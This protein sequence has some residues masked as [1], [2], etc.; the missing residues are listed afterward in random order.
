MRG[1][2]TLRPQIRPATR[3]EPRDVIEL[4]ALRARVP[5][6]ATAV[7]LQL[8]Q[9]EL[10]RRVQARVPLPPQLDLARALADVAAGRPVLRFPDLPMN[11]S[12]FR[13]GLRETADLLRRFE[14]V[15]ASLQARVHHLM[16]E[17]HTME[18]LVERWFDA[19]LAGRP[20][21]DEEMGEVFVRAIKPFLARS[22]EVWAP[23][24]DLS[25][26]RRGVCPLCSAP[27]ELG[28]LQGD[29]DRRLVCERCTARWPLPPEQCPWCGEDRVD[30]R[31]TLST[32]D[33]KYQLTACDTCRRY[34][35]SCDERH[36]GRPTLPWVDS[37]ATMP[38]DA[39]AMQRG[40]GG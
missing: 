18:P 21:E 17:G 40:Y 38:L 15:D 23:R 7:D 33:R 14:L 39:A 29:G 34:L 20:V 8:A 9:L 24:L 10:F 4:K 25:R 35:K 19:A 28:I 32:S 30:R 6:L 36:L 2:V 5:E 31:T 16:R 13:W 3:S 27:P 12:D 26:W 11:W 1:D 37:V 22:A